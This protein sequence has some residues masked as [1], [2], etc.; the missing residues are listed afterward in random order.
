MPLLS[1][2]TAT[3]GNTWLEQLESGWLC[4]VSAPA[5]PSL[6]DPSALGVEL[7]LTKSSGQAVAGAA[8]AAPASNQPYPSFK[9]RRVCVDD[10]AH[11][12]SRGDGGLR[13]NQR[14]CTYGLVS[15]RQVPAVVSSIHSQPCC[16]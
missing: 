13:C 6:L 9:V 14:R 15:G 16:C 11:G 12:V 8:S 4:D 3:A 10:V 2:T 7:V 5:R 1:S